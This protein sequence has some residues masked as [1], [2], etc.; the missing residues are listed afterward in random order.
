MGTSLR[1]IKTFL[2]VN[3]YIDLCPKRRGAAEGMYPFVTISREFGAGAHKLAHVMLAEMERHPHPIFHG[4]Q[5]FDRQ[6]C[7]QLVRDRSLREAIEAVFSEECHSEVEALLRNLLGIPS[8]HPAAVSEL[9][10]I[11]R[12]VAT[13]GK[14][15]IVGRAASCVTAS[16]PLGVHLRLVAPVEYRLRQLGWEGRGK[17]ALKELEQQDRDRARLVA[18]YFRRD[19]ADPT[20]YD[21]VWNTSRVPF[22][23]IARATIQLIEDRA[24]AH[25]LLRGSVFAAEPASQ[26]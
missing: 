12:L 25:G 18:T 10:R 23:S 14:V 11:I 26:H 8:A 5:I 4:W 16:L 20:L 7:E 21:A 22:P 2:D 13:R 19:I 24:A 17:A 15:I 6:L 3:R 9:F 1:E